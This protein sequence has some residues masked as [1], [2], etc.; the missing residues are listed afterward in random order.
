MA[1]EETPLLASAERGELLDRKKQRPMLA[2][3]REELPGGT[4]E[5]TQLPG[6]TQ[7]GLPGGTQ[8]ELLG[9]PE[10]EQTWTEWILEIDIVAAILS[11]I[12]VAVVFI[13]RFVFFEPE[14]TTTQEYFPI[15]ESLSVKCSGI[16]CGVTLLPSTDGKL[17]LLLKS[18]NM[19]ALD[20]LA[21]DSEFHVHYRGADTSVFNVN[22]TVLYTPDLE[23]FVHSSDLLF[24]GN[25]GG[26]LASLTANVTSAWF[27]TSMLLVP[28]S[29]RP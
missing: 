28:G 24:S 15:S 6:G 9:G 4:R 3:G 22:V 7:E 19:A 29:Q 17:K 1:D 26:A 21:T 13:I 25:A 2:A 10:R 20:I 18:D 14:L 16:E 8:E 27:P 12:I 5:Q 11:L 23:L